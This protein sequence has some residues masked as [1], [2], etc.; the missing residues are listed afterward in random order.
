MNLRGANL[1]THV[2]DRIALCVI[3]P[4]HSC[5]LQ[6]YYTDQKMDWGNFPPV[7]QRRGTRQVSLGCCCQNNDTRGRQGISPVNEARL[8]PYLPSWFSQIKEI[9]TPCSHQ[10]RMTFFHESC[11]EFTLADEQWWDSEETLTGF[12][13]THLNRCLGVLSI[14][15][16]TWTGKKNK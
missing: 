13:V 4:S 8:L 15:S 6:E 5:I 2:G 12:V 14:Y 1:K 7:C 9:Y 10:L 11:N 3:F 16:V